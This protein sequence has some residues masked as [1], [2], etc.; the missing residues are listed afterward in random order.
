MMTTPPSIADD[1]VDDL[2][3]MAK[4]LAWY[5]RQHGLDFVRELLRQIAEEPVPAKLWERTTEERSITTREF[6]MK[7]AAE[8]RS[9]GHKRLA[10]LVEQAAAQRPRQVDLCPY[11]P[12]STNARAWLWMERQ[13]AHLCPFC[14]SDR[15]RSPEAV[16][17]DG[18]RCR[19]RWA[20]HIASVPRPAKVS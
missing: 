16:C 13:R 11:E 19:D 6:L 5:N 12:G 7:A 4:L 8:L 9:V 15:I 20:S 3:S 17:D 10:V 1:P 14:G 2:E 18:R